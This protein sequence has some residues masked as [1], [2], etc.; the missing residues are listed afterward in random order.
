MDMRGLSR[1]ALILV[2]ALALLALLA[3]IAASPLFVQWYTHRFQ[4]DWLTLGNA[5]QAYGFISAILSALAFWAIAWSIQLQTKEAGAQRLETLRATHIRMFELALNDPYLLACWPMTQEEMGKEKRQAY[6][7][8]LLWWW[9]YN[10][11]GG[12]GTEEELRYEVA[13]LLRGEAGREFLLR[14]RR[15]RLEPQTRSSVRF[16]Q[17]VDEEY[18]KAILTGPGIPFALDVLD[19]PSAT[20]R[21]WA[22]TPMKAL[23]LGGSGLV[24][25]WVA[26]WLSG[27]IKR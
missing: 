17:I 13:Y 27:S 19:T 16:F 14:N 10:F 4:L 23:Y 21:R 11:C 5:G 26:R 2:S 7:N 15:F 9:H 25:G 20:G 18:D 22:F 3:L 24:I 1:V 6:L 12:L 8:L